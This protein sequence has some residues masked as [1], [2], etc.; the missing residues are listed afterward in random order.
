MRGEYS[1][2]V[3]G[4]DLFRVMREIKG[5]FD[6]DNRMNPG[7]IARPLD[8][9]T[10]LIALDAV[11]MRG[12]FDEQITPALRREYA[13]MLRCDGNSACFNQDEGQAF[14]PSYKATGDRR[15]SPKTRAGMLR[16]WALAQS[17]GRETGAPSMDLKHV[18]DSCLSCKACA[19]ASCPAQV[20]IPQMKAQFL[21][22]YHRGQRRPVQDH[23]VAYLETLTP[24]LDRIGSGLLNWVQSMV[25][26]ERLMSATFGL[27]DLPKIRSRRMFQDRLRQLDVKTLTAAYILSMPRDKRNVVIVQDCFTSFYD[28]DVVLAQVELVRKL[29]F[30][31]ILL[32]YRAGGK[33]L[34]VKGFLHRFKRVAMR[35]ARD[36][37]ALDKA[38]L[39]LIGVD[40]ATTLM[41]R[42]EYTETLPDCPDFTVQLLSEWLKNV[43]LP[44]MSTP[45]SYKLIQHCTER[46]LLPETSA[47]WAQV[48][49][50]AGIDTQIIKAGCCGM[51]GLFGHEL[52]HQNMS[53]TLYDQSWRGTA[54]G[55][56]PL[57]ATGYSC[58]SQV[59]RLSNIKAFHPA[60]VLLANWPQ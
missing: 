43:P 39:P 23:V 24:L 51:S 56:V 31:P 15:L 1:E 45:N 35:N 38:G 13:N 14:C 41:Y 11:D 30:T 48:F 25:L 22:W 10:P 26:I 37:A 58:R 12:A 5:I 42:H 49:A 50:R 44:A 60:Q 55:P 52:V 57:I 16:E 46:A 19:S 18:L 4:S 6:P 54:E 59:K 36:L 20:D 28:A 29:G 2:T 34:H 40:G 53:R 3:I 47:Q 8:D 9:D 17:T 33:P 7:K 21:D 32:T 27:V